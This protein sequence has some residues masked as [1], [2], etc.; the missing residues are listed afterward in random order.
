MLFLDV[1]FFTFLRRVWRVLGFQMGAKSAIF[2]SQGLPQS[3]QNSVLCPTCSPGGSKVVAKNFPSSILELLRRDFEAFRFDSGVP[4]GSFLKSCWIH[5]F[6]KKY[7]QNVINFRGYVLT[8]FRMDLKPSWGF[9]GES[10]RGPSHTDPKMQSKWA[11][12]FVGL[13]FKV[14]LATQI[15]KHVPPKRDQF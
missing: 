12:P 9:K 13:V 2:V 11:P 8:D 7:P 15:D 6:I 14:V 3:L 10:H 4:G 5:K 1:D